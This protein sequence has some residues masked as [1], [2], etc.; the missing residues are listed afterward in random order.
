[1]GA[2]TIGPLMF[3]PDRFAAVLAAAVFVILAELMARRLDP[4]FGRWSWWA[5]GA[6]ILGARLGHIV[7]HGSSFAEEPWRVLALWQGGFSWP[8]GVLAAAVVTIAYLRSAKAIAWAAVP[9][10]L[11]GLAAIIALHQFG[12]VPRLPLPG[13][14]YMSLDGRPVATE[15]LKGTPVVMNLWATWCPPC[16]RELPMM[17][18]VADET[19]GVAFVFVNQAETSAEV[20]TFLRDEKLPLKTVLLDQ[21][22]D[23][24]RHYQTPGL[25]ATL[26][27]G[28]DGGLRSII[29]GE[30]SRENLI[31]G[32]DALKAEQAGT[33]R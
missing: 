10:G 18:E 29:L 6:F 7:Q 33:G 27:I 30:I 16:R 3:A 22:A 24:A 1:M 12:E 5:L 2:I 32:I 11:C 15:S 8:A 31:A 26:F 13:G 21:R 28:A 9:A 17:A 20:S 23:V 14:T 4:R 25:P 19:T